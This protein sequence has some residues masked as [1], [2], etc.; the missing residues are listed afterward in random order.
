LRKN[1]IITRNHSTTQHSPSTIPHSIIRDNNITHHEVIAQP[2][3]EQDELEE[4]SDV[5]ED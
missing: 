5:G 4:V 2:I 3:E 1:P